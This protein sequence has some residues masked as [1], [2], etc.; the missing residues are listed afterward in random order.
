[1]TPIVAPVLLLLL[2]L[3]P[4]IALISIPL[5]WVYPDRHLHFYDRHGTPSQKARLTKWRAAYDQLGIRGRIRRARI[6]SARKRRLSVLHNR[7][8]QG[9]GPPH[10]L[11]R[12]LNHLDHEGEN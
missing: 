9:I 1:M 6:K 2:L 11:K 8:Q 5:V 12:R 4:V 7:L 3:L 10:R